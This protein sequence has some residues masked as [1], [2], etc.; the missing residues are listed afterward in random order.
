MNDRLTPQVLLAYDVN[1]YAG[2]VGPSIKWLITNKWT[3]NFGLNVK[4]GRAKNQFDDS[5]ST[6]PFP[7]YTDP[8]FGTDPNTALP[9]Q[10]A[11]GRLG[12]ISPL[13]IFRTGPLGLAESEDELQLTV[14]YKF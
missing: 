2:V 12:G 3:V 5:R 10:T 8:S 11:A 4:F 13:G 7:P 6:N 14:R 9:G 1:A